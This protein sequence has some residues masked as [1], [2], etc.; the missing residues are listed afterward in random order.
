MQTPTVYPTKPSGP[1]SPKG[2]HIGASP[3]PKNAYNQPDF[4]KTTHS[5]T[6]DSTMSSRAK[7]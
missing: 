1:S 5:A 4:L 2:H 7:G 3:H 6:D